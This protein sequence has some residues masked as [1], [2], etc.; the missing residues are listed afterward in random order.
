M[1]ITLEFDNEEEA[2]VA[3]DGWKYKEIIREFDQV[4]RGK[5]K[6]EDLETISIGEARRLVSA[7]AEDRGV[8][9]I[10]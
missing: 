10:G 8:E 9:I 6:Y 2:R 1:K 3:M 5:E 7:L 4:L